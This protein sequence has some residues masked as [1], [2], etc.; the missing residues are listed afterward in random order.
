MGLDAGP[1]AWST[2]PL[3][4]GR[5]R[6]LRYAADLA[7]IDLHRITLIWQRAHAPPRHPPGAGMVPHLVGALH[8]QGTAGDLAL[9]WSVLK[10]IQTADL[11]VE[12]LQCGSKDLLLEQEARLA[13]GKVCAAR[14]SLAPVLASPLP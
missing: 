1:R 2:A 9:A 5:F 4:L 11:P 7:G 13:R 12:P 14:L 10:V 6:E 8:L 3:R